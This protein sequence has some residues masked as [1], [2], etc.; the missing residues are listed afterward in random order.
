MPKPNITQICDS[1]AGAI[2]AEIQSVEASMVGLHISEISCDRNRSG[3][4]CRINVKT[5][6][7]LGM[8]ENGDMD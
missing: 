4:V 2:L 1:L 6:P 7:V 8:G 3:K 5:A